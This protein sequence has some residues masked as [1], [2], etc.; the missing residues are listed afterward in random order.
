MNIV[1]LANHVYALPVLHYLAQQKQ[2]QAV[3]IPATIQEYNLQV[4]RA[5]GMHGIPCK[6][7]SRRELHHT[8]SDWL[9]TQ[10]TEI[11]IAY[12][13]SFRIPE[14]V[15]SIPVFGFFNVHYSLLPAYRGPF[16]VFWQMKNGDPT[17]G[18]TIHRMSGEFDTGPVVFQQPVPVGAGDTYGTYSS[19]LGGVSL[20]LVYQL[21]QTLV[22][23]SS[24]STHT[25]DESRST[26]FSRPGPT[27]LAINWTQ[28]T[29]VEIEALVNAC[30]YEMGGAVTVFR[31]QPVKILEVSQ[32]SVQTADTVPGTIVHSDH[33]NGVFVACRNRQFLRINIIQLT[34]G[35]VSGFRLAAF[36]L[37]PGER[38]EQYTE[39]PPI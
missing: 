15:L 17:G 25:Q 35:V 24:L 12:T 13:F 27:D 7:I 34:E 6:R 20:N 1:L 23:G 14:K 9:K 19:K 28:N 31:G 4:E 10:Q 8:F 11:V 21:L 18:V 3:V 5:A 22:N 32:A 2:L 33:T 26:Y 38:F 30:N 36:G 16:P 39:T 29:A 37:K